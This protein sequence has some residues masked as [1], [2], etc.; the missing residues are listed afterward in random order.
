M[1]DHRR[2][3]SLVDPLRGAAYVVGLGLSILLVGTLVAWM[4]VQ[5]MT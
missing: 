2:W 3:S 1:T 4:I 5:V